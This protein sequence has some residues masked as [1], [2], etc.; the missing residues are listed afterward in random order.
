MN[1]SD[2]SADVEHLAARYE[3]ED[4]NTNAAI[5]WEPLP[6]EAAIV[7]ERLILMPQG[8]PVQEWRNSGS[9]C[10][11]GA[12][13]DGQNWDFTREHLQVL[14]SCAAKMMRGEEAIVEFLNTPHRRL[15]NETPIEAAIASEAGFDQVR[16]IISK[17]IV[18][19]RLRRSLLAGHARANLPTGRA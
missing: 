15:D 18:G 13:A 10:F 19:Q 14:W 17:R 1:G 4:V 16:T 7:R 2:K 8:T 9:A 12:S 3:A 5:R 11:A 6:K